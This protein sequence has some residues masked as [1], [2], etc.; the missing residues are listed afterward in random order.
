VYE[1]KRNPPK[2]RIVAPVPIM[3]SSLG[4]EMLERRRV[5]DRMLRSAVLRSRRCVGHRTG[6]IQTPEHPLLTNFG[7]CAFKDVG[8]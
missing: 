6:A 8:E 3:L 7:E 5:P 1:R 4:V 2:R